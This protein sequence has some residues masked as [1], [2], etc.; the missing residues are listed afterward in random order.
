MQR[1][2]S[3]CK[4]CSSTE[5]APSQKK[6]FPQFHYPMTHTSGRKRRHPA[7]SISLPAT[8]ASICI[9]NSLWRQNKN[10]TTFTTQLFAFTLSHERM[11]LEENCIFPPLSRIVFKTMPFA[12]D[13]R[14]MFQ[15]KLSLNENN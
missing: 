10:L 6:G 5:D 8:L 9:R 12:C 14:I 15:L 1:Y 13:I 11:L 4:P 3:R 7:V 2:H